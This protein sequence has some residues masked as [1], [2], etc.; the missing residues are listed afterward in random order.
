MTLLCLGMAGGGY[1][2]DGVPVPVLRCWVCLVSSIGYNR[3][4]VTEACP[5]KNLLTMKYVL[6]TVRVFKH[7]LRMAKTTVSKIAAYAARTLH[8]GRTLYAGCTPYARQRLSV[9]AATIDL[10]DQDIEDMA[11][12]GG[13]QKERTIKDRT[14]DFGYFSNFAAK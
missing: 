13:G 7:G 4:T 3:C 10:T 6:R 2:C 11:K 14:R 8:A 5:D 12:P 1:H 9:L